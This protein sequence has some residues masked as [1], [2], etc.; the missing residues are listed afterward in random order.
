MANAGLGLLRE[1][2]SGGSTALTAALLCRR[3]LLLWVMAAV[4]K[5]QQSDRQKTEIKDFAVMAPAH[6]QAASCLKDCEIDVKRFLE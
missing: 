3:G 4:S 1:P 5:S 6:R 2:S